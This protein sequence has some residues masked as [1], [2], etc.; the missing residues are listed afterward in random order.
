MYTRGGKHTMD[1]FMARQPIFDRNN[2]VIAYELLFRSGCENTYNSIDGNEATLNVI[3]NSVY[4]NTITD[5]KKAFINFTE[6]LIKE[7]IAT[8]LPCENVVIEILENIEPTDEILNACKKLKKQGYTL[9]LDDF[10][11]DKKYNKLIEIIDIIKVDFIITRGYD[12][13]KIFDLLK[14]NKKIKFLAEKVETIEEYNEA[15]YYGYEYFQGYYFSKPTVL[16]AKS[17]PTNK[18]AG[19]EIL[20]LINH[21]DFDYSDL[22]TL[23]LED[24]GLSYKIIKLINSSAYSL[25]NKVNSI[26]YAIT[27]LGE[28]EIIKWLYIVLLND[29]KGKNSDELIR[30]SLQRAKFCELICNISIYK[31]KNFSAYITG[32]FSVMDA[33]L[34]CSMESIIKDLNISDEVKEGLIGEENILNVMLNLAISY[35]RG[36]W[37]KAGVY[38]EKINVD[39]NEISKIYLETLKWVDNIQCNEKNNCI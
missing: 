14:I 38:A 26:R 1:V 22:E 19:L 7:E 6:K 3:A 8:I 11:F 33:I 25:R 4:F 29:L 17:I 27:F 24:V 21:K 32:L 34:N 16:T 15:M 37:E 5:N 23:I 39:I 36:E 31:E 9:A 12:R 35:G 30:V 2:H 18:Y 20:K 28:K 13:K 10:V